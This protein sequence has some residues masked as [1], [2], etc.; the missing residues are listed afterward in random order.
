[1]RHC[2][3]VI[4]MMCCIVAFI[5][6]EYLSFHTAE[7]A[8]M[9]K[10]ILEGYLNLEVKEVGAKMDKRI[11][12]G[13]L[14]LEV[15]EVVAKMGLEKAEWWIE[16]PPD[17]LRGAAYSLGDKSYIKFYIGRGEELYRKFDEK[18]KWDYKAFLD[19]KIGG[20]QYRSGDTRID[21]GP[22]VPFQF[23]NK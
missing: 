23:R 16:E 22:D 11:L 10:R 20:I 5:L 8:K 7:E 9:D 2:Y 4:A 14:N 17:V 3:F 15:K 21:V 12:E 6:I 13:Y 19:C 18:H 1:M